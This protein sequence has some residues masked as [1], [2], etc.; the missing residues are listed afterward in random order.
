MEQS[1]VWYIV[2]KELN[3]IKSK[4][5]LHK[6]FVQEKHFPYLNIPSSPDIGKLP[7]VGW[8]FIFI[9]IAI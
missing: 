2:K 1:I 3:S 7:A 8:D 9:D 6:L 4:N 5:K